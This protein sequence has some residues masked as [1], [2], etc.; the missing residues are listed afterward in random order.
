MQAMNQKTWKLFFWITSIVLLMVMP[1]LSKYYGMNGDEDIE[2]LYGHDVYEYFANGNLQCTD[3]NN[4]FLGGH[5]TG[6][7]YY[8]SLLP[9]ISE[10]TH[11]WL[12]TNLISTRHFY[13]S[14]YGA[15]MMI[16][17]GLFAY[18]VAGRNWM[19]GFLAL[20]FMIFCPRI[21]GESM[22]NGKD[23]P[24]ASG[25]IIGITSCYFF[26]QAFKHNE[27]KKLLYALGI[28]V[29]T[30]FAFG[31]R[32]GG[33][34]MQIAAYGIMT[35]LFLAETSFR[36]NLE[37]QKCSKYFFTTLLGA[38]ILGY[39]IAVAVWPYSHS[40]PIGNLFAA[41]RE[42]SNRNV[43][44]RVLF[45]GKYASSKDMPWYYSTKWI[46][47]T[48]SI[49][50][51]IA[52]A[53]YIA[54]SFKSLR[55][56]GLPATAVILFMAIFP[57]VYI[58]YKKST[59]FDTW[60]HLFFVF[61]FWASGAALFIHYLSSKIT[62]TKLSFLPYALAVLGLLPEIIWTFTTNPYQQVYFN[63]FV[64]GLKGA[65]GYYDL[66]YYQTSNREMALWIK[67]NAR[68]KPDGSKV[69][70]LSNMEGLYN[71]DDL[72][73]EGYLEDVK[74]RIDGRYARYYER[75]SKDWDYY[76][77]YSRFL[78]EWQLQNG[79]FPPANAVYEIKVKGVTI[80]AIL[81]RKSD[82]AFQAYKAFEAKD[83][84]KAAQLYNLADEESKLCDENELFHYGIAC[85]Q[86]GE[87]EKGIEKINAAIALDES[88]FDFYDAL[89]Q[90][91]TIMGNKAEADK[92]KRRKQQFIAASLSL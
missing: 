89:I 45:E 15:L 77:T 92:V 38:I 78:S 86:S 52:F 63:V 7:E 61:P 24:F 40:N 72:Y 62:N 39:A 42:M 48:N 36:K 8:G 4:H 74:D 22:H 65:Q 11:R 26:L 43:E 90:I 46:L 70:V 51:I 34:L 19:T 25:I 85:V 27:S 3:Y 6:S 16:F 23:I 64:G 1:S 67:E 81:E 35:V 30:A 31:A 13:I 88:R 50:V 2:M 54:T 29:G 53:A 37:E 60:R 41:M 83:W 80:A 18:R 58:V 33:A 82:L 47:M 12:G 76:A 55:K 44:F 68:P 87:V 91:Y 5:I 66:D 20:L 59:I 10:A 73:Y 71:V 79:K 69:K 9:L 57:I 28:V 56:Y 21:F 14:I 75:F 32:P 17:T 49:L 84:A